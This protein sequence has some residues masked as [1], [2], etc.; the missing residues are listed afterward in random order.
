VSRRIPLMPH[1]QAFLDRLRVEELDEI[2][3]R[4]SG[5]ITPTLRKQL[6]DYMTTITPAL[7]AAASLH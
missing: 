2:L 3:A 5:V 7:P 1:E 6:A 4:R